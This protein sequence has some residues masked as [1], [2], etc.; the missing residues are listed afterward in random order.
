MTIINEPTR[1]ADI[2]YQ[3]LNRECYIWIWCDHE[4]QSYII[5]KSMNPEMDIAK[6]YIYSRQEMRDGLLGIEEEVN[7]A[8]LKPQWR[9]LRGERVVVNDFELYRDEHNNSFVNN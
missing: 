5:H 4:S 2:V 8:A 7:M 3:D 9:R 6:F 1:S